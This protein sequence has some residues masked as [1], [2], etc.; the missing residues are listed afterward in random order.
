MA[1]YGDYSIM[2]NPYTGFILDKAK[3]ELGY[4][5]HSFKESLEIIDNQ[6]NH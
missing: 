4:N 5:P 1:V 2:K 3:R 6:L